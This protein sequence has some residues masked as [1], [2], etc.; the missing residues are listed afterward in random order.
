MRSTLGRDFSRKQ[1]C[2]KL[3][4]G[5]GV[6]YKLWMMFFFKAKTADVYTSCQFFWGFLLGVFE[7]I[8]TANRQEKREALKK[9][10]GWWFYWLVLREKKGTGYLNI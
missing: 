5:F 7:L 8:R 6:I 10:G 1:K 2:M 4:W 9:A 3:F